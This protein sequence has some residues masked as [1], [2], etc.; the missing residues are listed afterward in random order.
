MKTESSKELLTVVELEDNKLQIRV[1]AA[2]Y[3]DPGM[4]GIVLADALQN[5]VLSMLK[6]GI[7]LNG[8]ALSDRE[9]RSRI[10]EIFHKEIAQPTS[11]V[12]HKR[13]G[14]A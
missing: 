12:D 6:S 4:W 14:S 13:S 9:I 11:E 7:T 10:L 5:I 8:M 1:A 2:V 3:E